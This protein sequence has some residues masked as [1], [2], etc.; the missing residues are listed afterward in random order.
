ML[1]FRGVWGGEPVSRWDCCTQLKS[2]GKVRG[3]GT[4]ESPAKDKYSQ[5]EFVSHHWPW[6]TLTVTCTTMRHETSSEQPRVQAWSSQSYLLLLS[7]VQLRIEIRHQTQNYVFVVRVLQLTEPFQFHMVNW[8]AW[9]CCQL[10]HLPTT[11]GKHVSINTPHCCHSNE[12]ERKKAS[13]HQR[14]AASGDPATFTQK[15]KSS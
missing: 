8:A 10:R 7:K 5:S 3:D 4:N 9:V 1:F 14:L 11:N 13:F 12:H 2:E 6:L 15:S